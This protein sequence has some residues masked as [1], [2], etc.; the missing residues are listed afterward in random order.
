MIPSGNGEM[1][2]SSI[3]QNVIRVVD[4]VA[5]RRYGAAPPRNLQGFQLRPL[6]RNFRKRHTWLAHPNSSQPRSTLK[7]KKDLRT[8]R[9]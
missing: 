4:Y 5:R 8:D 3:N 9:E 7:L 2:K 1:R 6:R